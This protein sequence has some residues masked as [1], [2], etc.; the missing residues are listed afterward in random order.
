[1]KLTTHNSLRRLERLNQGCIGV[2]ADS[3]YSQ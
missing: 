1:M 3:H 2:W